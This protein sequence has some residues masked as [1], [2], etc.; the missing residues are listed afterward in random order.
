MD[1]MS[2]LGHPVAFE[3]VDDDAAS[4]PD[5]GS[6]PHD[7]Q[8]FEESRHAP[9]ES[10]SKASREHTHEAIRPRWGRGPAVPTGKKARDRSVV[11][12]QGYPSVVSLHDQ[13][14][15][16]VNHSGDPDADHGKNDG[17]RPK[18]RRRNG[19]QR[20]RHNL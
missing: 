1:G 20:D 9:H 19:P 15:S 17:L 14:Y 10:P 16:A 12:G 5:H 13:G 18:G 7:A 4:H 2:D 11:R 3:P 8:A 6:R